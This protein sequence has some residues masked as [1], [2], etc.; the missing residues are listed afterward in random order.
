MS[1]DRDWIVDRI[2][3]QGSMCLIDHVAEWDE[4]MIRC[5]VTGHRAV[6]HPLRTNGRLHAAC[7][8]EY[9][10]QAMAVHGAL[11]AE[12]GGRPRHGYLT[13]LRGVTLHVARLDDLPGEM[14]VQAECLSSDSHNLLYR[15]SVSHAGRCLVDGRAAVVLDAAKVAAVRRP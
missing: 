13:S 5:S 14:S 1:I 2:P 8:I 9:A 10:A 4:T 15:F 7:G 6:D 12:T 11:L 3:H